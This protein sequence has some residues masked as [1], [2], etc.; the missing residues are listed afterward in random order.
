MTLQN[1]TNTLRSPEIKEIFDEMGLEHL[2][3][4][5]SYARGEQWEWS[6]IDFLYSRKRGKKIW[7]LDFMRKKSEL[8]EKLGKKID[9]VNEKYVYQDIKPYLEADKILIY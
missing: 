4:V 9:L 6:D 5:G 8:E 3:L 1:L 7:A 2:Y